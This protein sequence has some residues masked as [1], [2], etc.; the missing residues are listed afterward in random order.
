MKRTYRLRRTRE[1][2]PEISVTPAKLER[3]AN[4]RGL[5]SDPELEAAAAKRREQEQTLLLRWVRR[6]MGRRLTTREQR[7]VELYYLEAMTLEEVAR[8]RKIH[9][10]TV[11]R[12]LRRAVGKLRA[13]A[14]EM[15]GTEEPRQ[16]A[17]RAMA[18]EE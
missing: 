10:S 14:R 1:W 3:I 6:E 8:R 13:A 7:L 11:S 16:A 17:L 2:R 5:R 18:Q 4:H 9:F 15:A 12:S